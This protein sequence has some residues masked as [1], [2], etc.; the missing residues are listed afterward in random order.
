MMH[1]MNHG[2]RVRWLAADRDGSPGG[3]LIR[4]LV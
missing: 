3:G 1:Q 2:V 4:D